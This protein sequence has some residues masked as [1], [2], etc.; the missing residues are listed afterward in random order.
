MEHIPELA[1]FWAQDGYTG[2][3]RGVSEEA[4]IPVLKGLSPSAGRTMAFQSELCVACGMSSRLLQTF[5]RGGLGVL[6]LHLG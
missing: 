5:L 6:G 3:G 4:R 1:E 2:L